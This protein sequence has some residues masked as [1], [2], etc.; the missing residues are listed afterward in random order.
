M[1]SN[2]T[3]DLLRASGKVSKE[4]REAEIGQELSPEVA[5]A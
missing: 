2:C 1:D 5:S 4:V 3:G